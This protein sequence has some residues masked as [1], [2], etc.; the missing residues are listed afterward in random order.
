MAVFA[1]GAEA[2]SF[3][4][5]T[6]HNFAHET[7]VGRFDASSSRLAMLVTLGV[8][9]IFLPFGT[10]LSSLWAHMSLYQEALPG[11]ATDYFR[12]MNAAGSETEYK[13][14]MNTDGSW[15]FQKWKTGAFTTIGSTTAAVAVIQ[16]SLAAIDFQIVKHPTAGTFNVYK[17]G[18]A[19]FTFSGDTDTEATIGMLRFNGFASA[20]QEL[21]VSEVIIAD[22]STLN[23][24]ATTLAPDA[25]GFNTSWTGDYTAVDEAVLSTADFIE[26]NV[27]GNIETAGLANINGA[28]AAYNV[29][30]VVVS[31]Y[32]ANDSGSAIA[33]MQAV[34]R[35]AGSN[36][37]SANLAV[38]KDGSQQ[39]RQAVWNTNPNTTAAWSQAEVNALEAGVKTV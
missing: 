8:S 34:I 11:S 19:I 37:T 5:V 14:I 27:V 1:A 12:F 20:A 17:N 39:A 31:A 28:F 15:T 4:V 25:A 35:T 18:T 38:V 21:N 33:D 32:V 24:K 30:A 6:G 2:G 26:T 9:E 16:N 29:K 3:H 36:Y 7:G 23:W 10:S 22:E 13:V